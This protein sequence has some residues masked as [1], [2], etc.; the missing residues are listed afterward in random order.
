M[1]GEVDLGEL[2]TPE[3]HSDSDVRAMRERLEI[4]ER[5]AI[6]LTLADRAKALCTEDPDLRRLARL[7][8]IATLDAAA[9][10]EL[11]VNDRKK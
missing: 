9:F 3:E 10:E 2:I 4:G 6:L 5:E 7:A 8:E 11:Y 1:V